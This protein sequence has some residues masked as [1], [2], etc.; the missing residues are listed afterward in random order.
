M[1]K[2]VSLILALVMLSTLTACGG[3]KSSTDSTDANASAYSVADLLSMSWDEIEAAAKNE[4]EVTFAM[5]DAEEK[6]TPITKLFT[7]KYGIKVNL[8]SGDKNTVMDKILMELNGKASVDVIQLSGETVNG[9]MGADALATGILPIMREKDKLVPGLSAR[10]EGVSNESGVWVPYSTSPA[11]FLY[12]ANEL[13]PETLPQTLDELTAFIEANPGRFAMCI[14]E[15]GGTGQ[16]FMESLIA[17]LTGGLDQYLLAEGNVCDENLLAKWDTVWEWL[18]AHKDKITFTTSNDDGITR[19]NSGEVWLVTAWNSTTVYNEQSG[20]LSINHGLY[21]PDM[22]LCYSG[23]VLSVIK[24]S[25][26][27][28]AALLFIDWMTS[29]EA[30]NALADN[31]TLTGRTDLQQDICLLSAEDRAKNTEWMAAC[32]KTQYI[33]DFTT[34]VLQ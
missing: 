19:L 25:T 23:D 22:G 14:P 2:L 29:V 8:M 33:K 9:L 13:T 31:G 4:G 18:N 3:S 30:Q 1:K 10:K 5:W 26:H 6:W 32:Y 34:N 24:N 15:N 7:E 17:N 21:V 28:A 12:N 27:P 20:N 11:G 16:A